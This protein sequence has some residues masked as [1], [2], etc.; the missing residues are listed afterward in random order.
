MRYVCLCKGGYLIKGVW[1]QSPH[2]INQKMLNTEHFCIHVIHVYWSLQLLMNIEVL[3]TGYFQEPEE[4]RCT[5]MG[6]TEGYGGYKEGIWFLA[7]CKHTCFY[8]NLIS[9]TEKGLNNLCILNVALEATW[10][11]LLWCVFFSICSLSF[12]LECVY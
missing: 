7:T 9:M 10:K 4:I 11:D 6:K 2:S 1:V 5:H 12:S 8:V 3:C